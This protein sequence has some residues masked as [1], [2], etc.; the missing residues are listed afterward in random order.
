[1]T[2]AFRPAGGGL[3]GA[4]V[5]A[6]VLQIVAGLSPG[7]YLGRWRVGSFEEV[8]A[9]AETARTDRADSLLIAVPSAPA[10]IIRDV[11]GG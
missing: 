4:L 1:M 6:V 11:A 5:L 10:E 3:F 9:L 8:A 2:A 7:L